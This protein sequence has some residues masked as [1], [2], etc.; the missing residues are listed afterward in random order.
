[1]SNGAD[2]AWI[3]YI[4]FPAASGAGNV[5]NVNASAS[6]AEICLGESSQLNAF[7]SGGS[8]NYTYQWTP[9]TGLS[10]P[11][12]SN[13]VATPDETTN[14]SVTV[15]DGSSSVTDEIIL[16]VHPVP[17]T[18]EITLEDDHLVSSAGSGNQWYDSNGIISGATGQT[19]YPAAT[20]HFYAIVSNEF[21][22]SSDQ[23]N[24]IYFIYTGLKEN[25]DHRFNIYPNPFVDH[26]TVEFNLPAESDISICLYNK[27]GQKAEILYEGRKQ[28]PGFY[29]LEFP[30]PELNQGIY[31]ITINS[32]TFSV[33]RKLILAN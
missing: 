20:D 16:T 32:S 31:F 14:Y 13:P 23:S 33:T 26:F 4:V 12:S 10:D 17:E 29:Q 24:V 30:R 11:N 18:P 1:M 19:Y 6:P 3:D 22:C 25:M 5:L 28:N 9:E 27:L 21:G 8:G 15:N 2:C 7:A